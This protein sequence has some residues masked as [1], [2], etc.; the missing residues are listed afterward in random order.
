MKT[1]SFLL[2]IMLFSCSIVT[3]QKEPLNKGFARSFNVGYQKAVDA[4]LDAIAISGVSVQRTETLDNSSMFIFFKGDNEEGRI[5]LSYSNGSTLVRIISTISH[6]VRHGKRPEKQKILLDN[7]A[8][9]L[10]LAKH[11]AHR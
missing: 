7:I 10:D 1:L 11:T 3:I 4:T 8:L 5:Y 2:P 6:N 9:K